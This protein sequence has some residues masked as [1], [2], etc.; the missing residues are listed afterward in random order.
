VCAALK[1]SSVSDSN[2]ESGY[3]VPGLPFLNRVSAR[4]MSL[5]ARIF[6]ES[7]IDFTMPIII[8]LLNEFSL[9]SGSFD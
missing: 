3:R 8:D 4:T 6:D 7:R 1:I 9:C 2:F 5:I